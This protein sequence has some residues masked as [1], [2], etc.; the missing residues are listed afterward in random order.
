MTGTVA[1]QNSQD[2][3]WLGRSWSP[4]ISLN[5]A[6][7]RGYGP[8]HQP[9]VYRLR[10]ARLNDSLL[11]IGEGGDIR[12][13]LFQL[14]R[15]MAKVAAGGQC[16]PHWAGACILQRERQGAIVQVSWLLEAVLIE[17]ER[18]GLECEYIT[19]HQWVVGSNP[20]CQFI[21]LARRTDEY[22]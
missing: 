16:P 15:A 10:D 21:A 2:T 3:I 5:K 18:K 6:L 12:R 17:A 1:L 7:E 11:Y 20:D 4:W 8:P 19:A 22:S 9:G 13:R 14:R